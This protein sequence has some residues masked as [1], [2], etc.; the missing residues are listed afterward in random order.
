M[1]EDLQQR[2][3]ENIKS[4][5]ILSNS[6]LAVLLIVSFTG[7]VIGLMGW[8]HIPI[9]T[10]MIPE[11]DYIIIAIASLS[12]MGLAI[13]GGALIRNLRISFAEFDQNS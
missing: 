12:I 8:L 9:F 10:W 4:K 11:S 3:I 7:L 1:M 6:I 2:H 13:M 5:F